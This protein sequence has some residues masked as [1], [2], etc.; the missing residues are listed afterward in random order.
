M[1]AGTPFPN[2]TPVTVDAG[3]EKITGVVTGHVRFTH[4]E[5]EYDIQTH[6]GG[7]I[8]AQGRH[9]TPIPQVYVDSFRRPAT[10]GRVRARWSHLTADTPEALHEFAQRL[11]LR[12]D[13]FQARCKHGSCPTRDGVCAHFHYDVVDAKRDKALEA[14]AKSID[15]RE[16][17][18]LISARRPYYRGEQP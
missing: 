4:G 5:I 17:G 1:S 7:G 8:A 6:P 3:G 11:G 13:W 15:L 18:A 12:R 10:V 14:G 16:M 2:G 9:V